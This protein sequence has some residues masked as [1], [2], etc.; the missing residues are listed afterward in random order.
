L[1]EAE[2]MF[3]RVLESRLRVQGEEH[4][5]T[6]STA[7]WLAETYWRQGRTEEAEVLFSKTGEAMSRV[8]GEEHAETL[9]AMASLAKIR[10]ARST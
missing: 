10:N 9:L 5:E 8:L 6:L 7:A 3:V 2:E 4:P 1:K